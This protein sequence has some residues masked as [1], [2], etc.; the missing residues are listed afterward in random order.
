MKKLVFVLALLVLAG[1]GCVQTTSKKEISYPEP[2]NYVVNANGALKQPV[3]DKLNADLK[4]FD[5]KAQIAVLVLDST[6]SESIEQYGIHLADK[7][8]VGYKGKDNGVILILAIKDRKIRIEVG[9]G[10]E[11]DMPDLV[12]KQIISDITPWLKQGDWDS[13]VSIAVDKIKSQL[14]K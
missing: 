14:T 3:V 2:T 7:W 1:A 6:G 5:G 8:K 4:N 10:L 13:A 11:G 9:R 12:A